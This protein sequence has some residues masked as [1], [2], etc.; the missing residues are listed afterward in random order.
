MHTQHGVG[1]I[2][3]LPDRIDNISAVRIDDQVRCF[4][5]VPAMCM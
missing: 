3:Q 5:V 4:L 1:G 2:Q